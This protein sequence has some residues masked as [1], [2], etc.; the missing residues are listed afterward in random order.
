MDLKLIRMQASADAF[1]KAGHLPKALAAWAA[2]ADYAETIGK[3]EAA[4]A[5]R[6]RVAALKPQ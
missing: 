4:K 1:Y 6:E 2:A 3:D 5:L